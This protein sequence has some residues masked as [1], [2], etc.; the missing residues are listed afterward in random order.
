M[1]EVNP[2]IDRERKTVINTMDDLFKACPPQ[3]PMKIHYDPGIPGVIPIPTEVVPAA[4]A[5]AGGNAP[6]AAERLAD[7]SRI[8]PFLADVESQANLQYAI[9]GGQ[10]MEYFRRKYAPED[11]PIITGDYDINISAPQ[12]T[13]LNSQ[14]S[15]L[16][17]SVISMINLSRLYY[18][19]FGKA[20]LD[21]VRDNSEGSGAAVRNEYYIN[22]FVTF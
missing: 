19:H 15:Y 8:A 18:K 4:S 1:I 20:Y 9:Y 3:L 5:A 2:F 21:G 11:E 12:G 6:E 22:L 13:V 17:S 10:A 16:R 14:F 7:I